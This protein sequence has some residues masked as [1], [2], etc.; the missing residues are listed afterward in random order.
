[1]TVDNLQMDLKYNFNFDRTEASALEGEEKKKM[2]M[3]GDI[4]E[5]CKTFNLLSRSVSCVI[6]D[7]KDEVCFGIM[8]NDKLIN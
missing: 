1:M 2:E 5:L 7:E 3:E 6:V 4:L 8:K